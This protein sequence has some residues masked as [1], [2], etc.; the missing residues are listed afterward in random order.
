MLPNILSQCP[1]SSL[2]CVL[3]LL[4]R[5]AP[6]VTSYIIISYGQT[7]GNHNMVSFFSCAFELLH[8]NRNIRKLF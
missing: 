4:N 1:L 5:P 2:V 6:P 3:H 8:Y 7:K